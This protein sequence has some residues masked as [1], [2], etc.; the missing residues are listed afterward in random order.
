[1]LLQLRPQRRRVG[2]I[3]DGTRQTDYDT[4]RHKKAVVTQA[5]FPTG[6]VGQKL[7]KET[8]GT[9]LSRSVEGLIDSQWRVSR[10]KFPVSSTRAK[11]D[12]KPQTP[13]YCDKRSTAEWH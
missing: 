4:D 12:T 9:N 2:T 1:M 11:T 7:E 5:S 8:S 3:R 6:L 10:A 13:L